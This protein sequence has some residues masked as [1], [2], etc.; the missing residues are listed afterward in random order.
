MKNI[1]ITGGA[2]YIGTHTAVELLNKNYKVVIYDNLSN[3]SKIAVD[4]VEEI[5]GK[6]V[7]FYEADILDKEKI[8]K[9]EEKNYWLQLENDAIKK[10]I[11]L[12]QMTDTEIR[13]LLKQLKS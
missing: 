13:Q 5:T 11:E 10:K 9:L 2:G 7:S 1:M 4:R 3:S 6:K 8:K 12:S